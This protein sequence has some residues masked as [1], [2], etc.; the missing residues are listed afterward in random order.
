MEVPTDKLAICYWCGKKATSVEHVPPK[1]LFPNDYKIDLLTVGACIDHNEKFS[2]LD[3]RMRF[4]MTLMGDPEIA[5][6]QFE[7][8]VLKGLARGKSKGLMTDLF[9]N[10]FVGNNDKKWQRDDSNV[11][12]LYFE[13]I[14][15]GLFFYHYQAHVNGS[16]SYF[17]NKIQMIDMTADAHFYYYVLFKELNSRWI[18]GNSKNKSIFDY[19]YFFSEEENRFFTLMTFY[20]E[21]EVLG[22]TLPPN[23]TIDD[24]GL[25]YEEYKRRIK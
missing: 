6:N 7:K 15:R 5:R 18:N 21:H 9:S 25:D 16:T 1:N 19:K 14:I 10:S 17:S 12:S 3:E 24:Y 13:K 4:H 8:K 22:V 2:K 23:K 20:K 11:F